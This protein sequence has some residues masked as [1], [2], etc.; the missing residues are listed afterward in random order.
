MDC[1]SFVNTL[2]IEILEKRL[3]SQKNYDY[4]GSYNTLRQCVER[5][6]KLGSKVITMISNMINVEIYDIKKEKAIKFLQSF[7][8]V[9]SNDPNV[10][11]IIAANKIN[12]K[13]TLKITS[14]EESK[15]LSIYELPIKDN[16]QDPS[17]N[18]NTYPL[19]VVIGIVIHNNK[20]LLVKRRDSE[21]HLTWQFPAGILKKNK[22]PEVILEREVKSETNII[23]KVISN[24]GTRIHPNTQ[25]IC[26]YYLCEY[27]GGDLFNAD[28]EE[29]EDVQWVNINDYQKYITSD[30]YIKVTNV[31]KKIKNE[32]LSK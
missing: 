15:T 4:G 22:L 20:I 21:S 2:V 32:V 14:T 23:C 26:K 19:K 7:T 27:L 25:V 12:T 13:N 6:N 8:N 1:A 17:N 31:L 29:N 18:I 10:L 16:F 24:I 9:K 30:I 11:L 28:L 5:N 3:S